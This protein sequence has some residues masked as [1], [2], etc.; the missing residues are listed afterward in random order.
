MMFVENTSLSPACGKVVRND[1]LCSLLG[2][3]DA[4]TVN[5][6]GNPTSSLWS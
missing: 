1:L 2:S 3:V 5:T 4:V 6:A